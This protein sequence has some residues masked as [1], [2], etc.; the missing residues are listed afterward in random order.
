MAKLAICGME[1]ATFLSISFLI[2]TSLCRSIW[3]HCSAWPKAGTK[4]STYRL[5]LGYVPNPLHNLTILLHQVETKLKSWRSGTPIE[6]EFKSWRSGTPIETEFSSWRSL[7][8][9]ELNWG[10]VHVRERGARANV[11]FWPN[12]LWRA[13]SVEWRRWKLIVLNAC[14][15]AQSFLYFLSCKWW[16][17]LT[18]TLHCGSPTYTW[19]DN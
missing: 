10:W 5:V 1:K 16:K 15:L 13:A 12:S 3:L 2:I 7:R 4:M 8:A 9:E 6:T 14:K 19:I 18:S 17:L 11:C